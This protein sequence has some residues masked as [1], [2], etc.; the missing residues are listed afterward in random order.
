[1]GGSTNNL[2]LSVPP[3]AF[4]VVNVGRRLSL[5]ANAAVV[6]GGGMLSSHLVMNMTGNGNN[7]L[8]AGSR[9]VVPG[10]L[11]GP[12]IGG[13]FHVAF[14]SVI[15]GQNFNMSGVSAHFGGCVCP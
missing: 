15:P 10:T 3:D 5:S 13:N 4:F 9:N 7:L 12:R 1:M 11:L 6:V 14:G 8:N 2:T